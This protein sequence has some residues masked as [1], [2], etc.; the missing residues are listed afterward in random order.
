MTNV[1]SAKHTR[2]AFIKWAHKLLTEREF[3]M[4]NINIRFYRKFN[5]TQTSTVRAK[6][7][8]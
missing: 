8:H 4:E 5:R 1:A 6:R 3:E 2:M 7:V